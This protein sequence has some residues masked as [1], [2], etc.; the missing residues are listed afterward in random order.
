MHQ[1]EGLAGE[2]LCSIITETFV[3]FELLYVPCG[4]DEDF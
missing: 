4:R 2:I 3:F 1:H